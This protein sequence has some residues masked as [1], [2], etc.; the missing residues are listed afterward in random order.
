V[1]KLEEVGIHISMTE[2]RAADAERAA[3]DRF[4]AYWL[5]GRR[6]EGF[7]GRISG[8]GSFGVFVRLADSGAD[9]L[10]PMRRLPHDYYEIDEAGQR[11]VGTRS[12]RVLT[13]GDIVSVKLAEV[14]VLT[15]S[16]TFDLI[17]GGTMEP[18]DFKRRGKGV[19][20]PFKR[21]R[22]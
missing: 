6:G 20:H 19:R 16:V 15:G 2:R 21:G 8:V 12:G 17:D 3:N 10:A 18:V 5:A 1:D 11:L 22:R 7:Q 14:D 13:I 4:I 9:G